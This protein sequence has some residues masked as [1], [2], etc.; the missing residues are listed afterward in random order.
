MTTKPSD[1]HPLTPERLMQLGFAYAPPL[2]IGAAVSN[3]IFDSLEKGAKTVAQISRETGSSERGLRAVMNALVGLELLAKT[4]DEYAL[5]PESA[6]FLVSGKPGSLAGFFP[7][8]MRRLIP[9]WLKLDE[10]VRTGRPPEAR[11]QEHPGTEFF[12]ELVE[13]IIPMSY[14]SAN[15]LGDGLKTW[16]GQGASARTRRGEWLRHLGYCPGAK[17]AA[18]ARDGGGLGRNNSDNQTHHPEVRR[19]GPL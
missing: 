1:Q 18:R 9:L 11:N 2:I 4:G 19:G 8:N 15:A 14:G 7:M 3:K 5:T 16:R 13:N 17:V 10:A 6:A 12:Q